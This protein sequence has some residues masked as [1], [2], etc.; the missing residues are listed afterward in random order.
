MKK[1][2]FL[3]LI[4]IIFIAKYSKNQNINKYNNLNNFRIKQKY[5][6]DP[7]YDE[8]IE[9][10]EEKKHKVLTASFY[11]NKFH[12]KKTASGVRYHKDSLTA[13]SNHYKFG[14]LLKVI[15]PNNDKSIIVKVIDRMHKTKNRNI[16]LSP[17]AFQKIC[18]KKVGKLKV[19]I[20]EV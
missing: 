10:K 13:A 20:I 7:I 18:D 16:D 5:E 14:T 1:R 19:H 6:D 3:F 8:F 15:N 4:F 17:V 12:G 11:N 2:I 9:I